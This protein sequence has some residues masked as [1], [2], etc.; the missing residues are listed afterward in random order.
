MRKSYYIWILIVLLFF[1]CTKE[2]H[3]PVPPLDSKPVVNCL[4]TADSAFVIYVGKS[5]PVNDNRPRVI[6]DAGVY[7]YENNIPFDTLHYAEGLYYSTLVPRAG[8]E[9]RVDVEIPGFDTVYAEDIAPESPP[10]VTGNYRDSV[11]MDEDGYPVSQLRL[12]IPDDGSEENYY[13]IQLWGSYLSPYDSSYQNTGIWFYNENPDPVLEN[14]D[15]IQYYP[16]TIVF[17]DEMFNG[18]KYTLTLNYQKT[19]YIVGNINM[20][21]NYVLILCFRTVSKDYYLYKKRLIRHLAN[22]ESD[23][24]DGM[25]NPV[26]MYSNIHGG[27]GIFAGYAEVI[28]TIPK[29]K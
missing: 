28:D 11:M 14:E 13:E 8:T 19:F 6:E 20:D 1:S 21:Y 18:K 9:Y 10:P 12:T 23:I 22:Q 25:G 7:L 29:K 4:F 5:V 24:W 16:S 2:V 26:Q 27:Y 15:L 3:I 17:S